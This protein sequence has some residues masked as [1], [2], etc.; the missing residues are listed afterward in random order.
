MKCIRYQVDDLFDFDF[1]VFNVRR[2]NVRGVF[3]D[4]PF[5]RAGELHTAPAIVGQF[6]GKASPSLPH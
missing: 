4:A 3:F 6:V 2:L 1:H 5:R